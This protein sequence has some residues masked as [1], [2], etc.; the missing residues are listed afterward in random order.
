MQVNVGAMCENGHVVP[1]YGM[2]FFYIGF[3]RVIIIFVKDT[4]S[5]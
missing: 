3:M 5:W 2:S 4:L 1:S